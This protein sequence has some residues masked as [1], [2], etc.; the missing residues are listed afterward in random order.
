MS[1]AESRTPTRSVTRTRRRL[2]EQFV[3]EAPP[4]VLAGFE[5]PQQCV[6]RLLEMLRRMLAGR[7]V[8]TADVPARETKA[9]MQPAG[10]GV[11]ALLAPGRSPGLH[12]VDLIEMRARCCGHGLI[13]KG[14][15]G[16]ERRMPACDRRV[17]SSA[18]RA[19]VRVDERDRHCTLANS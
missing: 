7:I 10:P 5:A 6:G 16:I 18:R 11:E 17:T 15:R 2:E 8:A 4:P 9:Q 14:G 19:Q 13:R 1:E 12:I 3:D